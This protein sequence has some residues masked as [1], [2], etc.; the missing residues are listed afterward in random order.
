MIVVRLVVE[1]PLV[2]EDGQHFL[3]KVLRLQGSLTEVH[4]VNFGGS[5]NQD[6]HPHPLCN[7]QLYAV[8]PYGVWRKRIW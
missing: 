6:C 5:T 8:P 1:N 4:C 2:I 3:G 7:L